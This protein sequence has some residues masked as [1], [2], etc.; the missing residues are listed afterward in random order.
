M[1]NASF[2]NEQNKKYRNLKEKFHEII[3]KKTNWEDDV[4][5]MSRQIEEQTSLI[6][7]L[8]LEKQEYRKKLIT[9]TKEFEKLHRDL[10]KNQEENDIYS[11]KSKAEMEKLNITL[12]D[13][14]KKYL[15]EREI[16]KNLENYNSKLLEEN[17]ILMQEKIKAKSLYN[18]Y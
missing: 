12:Q 16:N 5:G 3:D 14:E 7:K 17:E 10:C 11:L 18:F 2:E 6:S 8:Q 13:L 9:K 15:K 1:N 4:K